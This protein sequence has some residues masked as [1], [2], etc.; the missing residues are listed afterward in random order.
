MS[1]SHTS[2][3]LMVIVAC[4]KNLCPIVFRGYN[5]LA[6]FIEEMV[7]DYAVFVSVV[8]FLARVWILFRIGSSCCN[9]ISLCLVIISLG[10]GLPG[11]VS[12]RVS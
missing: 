6:K 4:S 2:V 11:S 12:S 9:S 1:Y 5:Y 7:A 10:Y 8:S 3:L